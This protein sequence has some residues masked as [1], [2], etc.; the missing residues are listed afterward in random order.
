MAVN[1]YPRVAADSGQLK[2]WNVAPGKTTR[3]GLGLTYSG[4]PYP[5]ELLS[6]HPSLVVTLRAGDLCVINGNLVHA[7]LG[8]GRTSARDRLLLT[9]FMGL[10]DK[11]DALWWT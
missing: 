1:V 2:L 4:Y 8:R 10:D 3:D 9:C 5:P 7:V 6:E 11:G